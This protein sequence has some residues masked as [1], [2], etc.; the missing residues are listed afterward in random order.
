MKKKL[1]VWISA[2]NFQVAP[3]ACSRKKK[4]GYVVGV[5]LPSLGQAQFIFD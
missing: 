3:F 4:E 5:V 1:S 2:E